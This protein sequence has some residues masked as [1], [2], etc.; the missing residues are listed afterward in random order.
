MLKSSAASGSHSTPAAGTR[1]KRVLLV[2][3][4]TFIPPYD[5]ASGSYYVWFTL[6]RAAGC[7]V[8]VVS[9]NFPRVRWTEASRATLRELTDQTL[10]LDAYRT[11]FAAVTKQLAIVLWRL[12][13][14]RR[15]LPVALE[16]FWGRR[17]KLQ[18][19]QFLQE[20]T[21]DA[22]IVSKTGTTRLVG[23]ENLRSANARKI[24]DMRDN[25]PRRERL[26]QE[27]ILRFAKRDLLG[28]LSLLHLEEI[29]AL[30]NW[31]SESRM[32]REE[33][34]ILSEYDHVVFNA[35]EE[36]SA[37]VGAGLLSRRVQVIP[38]VCVSQADPTQVIDRDSSR[39][40][41]GL[42]G[43][44]ALFNVEGAEYFAREIVPA[45]ARRGIHP[46]IIIAGGVAKHARRLFPSEATVEL[47][48]WVA[49]ISQFYR[50]VRI[51]T[52]PLLSGTGISIKT[53]EAASYGAAIVTTS[54]GLRGTALRP[55]EDVLVADSTDDF[56]TALS[57]LLSDD[58]LCRELGRNAG[59]RMQTSHSVS[60]VVQKL[61]ALVS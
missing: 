42:I 5:G 47:T 52:I 3:D 15:F 59:K 39:Y 30:C 50:D 11:S 33:A 34:A 40:D 31:A 32:L 44:S 61:E 56:A 49:D 12:I 37:F 60:T 4:R 9:F 27:A 35:D 7:R 41:I 1:A 8:S 20:N 22:I 18:V 13:A 16:N 25:H 55:Y 21:F 51:V 6:L 26:T 17:Q 36:A 29:R 2:T 43:S 58:A 48:E 46:R 28:L 38:W 14:G 24:V 53:L 19:K 57:R 23:I 54:V 45:L 10:I